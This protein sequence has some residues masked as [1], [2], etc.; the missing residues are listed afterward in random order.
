MDQAINP[1]FSTIFGF[2]GK[3]AIGYIA[4]SA[5]LPTSREPR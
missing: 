3:N 5:Y 1:P 4:I 2:A